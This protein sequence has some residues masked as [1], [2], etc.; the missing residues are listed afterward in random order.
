MGRKEI[1]RSKI[2]EDA[3]FNPCKRFIVATHYLPITQY[4]Q[5]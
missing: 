5:A 1:K 2:Q 3:V 4:G